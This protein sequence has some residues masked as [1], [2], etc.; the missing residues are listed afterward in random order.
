MST[1]QEHAWDTEYRIKQMLSPSN[2]P[3]ADVV[4]FVRWLKKD[5]K[6]ADKPFD[7]SDCTVLDLGSGTGRNSYY[8]AEQGARTIGYEIS[9]TAL[10]MA[11]RLAARDGLFIEYRK[12]D[13]GVAYQLP[14][15][16]VDIVLDVTSSNSLSDTAR[17]T[18]LSEAHR[19]LKPGGWL[20]VR[21]LAKDG[22][23]HA[24]TLIS[25][26][27]GPDPDTYIHPDLGITEKVFTNESFKETYSSLFEIVHMEKT[28]HYTTVAGRKYKRNYW[29]AYLRRN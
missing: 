10:N 24:K 13:I 22:D 9:S 5:G 21:A 16:S 6:H 4:R 17:Q 7:I 18:Y 23:A 29:I 8:L 25:R 12:Q 11:E 1:N 19:V 3:Q 28:S 20:F 27:P 15:A 2:V 26:F 14:T